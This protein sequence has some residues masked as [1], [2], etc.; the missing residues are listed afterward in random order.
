MLA[1]NLGGLFVKF[2]QQTLKKTRQ[3]DSNEG[4]V[5]N[6]LDEVINKIVLH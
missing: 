2:T 6:N 4:K 1:P 3:L 5:T